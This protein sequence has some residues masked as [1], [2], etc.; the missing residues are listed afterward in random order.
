MQ[1]LEPLELVFV[2]I[3]VQ[4]LPIGAISADDA[5]VANG[6]GQGRGDDALLM[7]VETG[8][9][10]LYVKTFGRRNNGHAVIGFLA[11]P[12]CL[13]ADF[14]KGVQRKLVVDRKS[15]RLNSSH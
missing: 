5:Y 14:A 6:A 3:A 4:R 1:G 15:T 2:F 11:R 9:V 7:V 13:V 10:A 12:L 8:Y